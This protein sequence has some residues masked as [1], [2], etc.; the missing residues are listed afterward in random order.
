M[1]SKADRLS[2]PSAH[3]MVQ[4]PK[5]EHPG[6]PQVRVRPRSRQK[7]MKIS[8]EKPSPEQLHPPPASAFD[9]PYGKLLNELQA[10]SDLVSDTATE[11]VY[12]CVKLIEEDKKLGSI[13]I[14]AKLIKDNTIKKII[15]V[16]PPYNKEIL[17]PKKNP[18]KNNAVSSEI[19]ALNTIINNAVYNKNKIIVANSQ[20]SPGTTKLLRQLLFDTYLTKDIIKVNPYQEV[21]EQKN[22]KYFL[23]YGK[24]DKQLA[25]ILFNGLEGNLN[26]KTK[27]L[28]NTLVKNS[29]DS[30]IIDLRNFY[31]KFG[32]F[33]K[34]MI[35]E[36]KT[37]DDP[38][39]FAKYFESEI[40][41]FFNEYKE[42]SQ[43]YS[44]Y[45]DLIRNIGYF[46]TTLFGF[47]KYKSI[48]TIPDQEQKNAIIYMSVLMG[49]PPGEYHKA[50]PDL[51]ENNDIANWQKITSDIKVN[52]EKQS[53]LRNYMTQMSNSY[54]YNNF[55]ERYMDTV[56]DG[57]F[58]D[59]KEKINM[60]ELDDDNKKLLMYDSMIAHTRWLQKLLNVND[61]GS[62]SDISTL[63]KYLYCSLN[64]IPD[65]ETTLPW[66]RGGPEAD[67]VILETFGSYLMSNIG[68]AL[69]N[70]L[71]TI[72]INDCEGDDF[73]TT[74]VLGKL[75]NKILNKK[76]KL[77]TFMSQK[78]R[79]GSEK[80]V[81]KNH[82]RNGM[83]F[84]KFSQEVL[85][86]YNKY[87]TTFEGNNLFE[88]YKTSFTKIKTN[89][90]IDID[91]LTYVSDA[92]DNLNQ[93]YML[94]GG[95]ESNN[96]EACMRSLMLDVNKMQIAGKKSTKRRRHTKKR[97]STKKKKTNK[98][99][100]TYK[101]KKTN[102]KKKTYKKKMS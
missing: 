82:P 26:D 10:T 96:Y 40:T 72:L 95:N 34:I 1:F 47:I 78:A 68:P 15:I 29:K 31:N 54:F 46:T 22:D 94:F 58:K 27:K 19:S 91:S 92:L 50:A 4:Y 80:I 61:F 42:P 75:A 56:S 33:I 97:R 81:A 63:F 18:K 99:K 3:P 13:D 88:P 53:K 21:F 9:D 87:F 93:Q 77:L 35:E 62:V 32:A 43:Q 84:V 11:I 49:V 74:I 45:E 90:T 5:P 76:L 64:N 89:E 16:L 23:E 85:E 8:I 65:M 73:A 67:C 51:V 59:K 98:K 25:N 7:F 44:N 79:D 83:A 70:Y 100:K 57:D 71:P 69:E 6:L 102:K 39:A 12:H 20:T 14:L 37:Y 86:N 24:T 48:A 55:F 41:N 66:E 52:T 17:Q 60:E 2:I 38:Q 28:L 30:F 36:A 101:K